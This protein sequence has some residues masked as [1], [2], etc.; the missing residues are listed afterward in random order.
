MRGLQNQMIKI[1]EWCFVE[2]DKPED[3]FFYN[4]EVMEESETEE[5]GCY[6]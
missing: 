3:C 6:E 1:C 4:A 2:H 5:Q